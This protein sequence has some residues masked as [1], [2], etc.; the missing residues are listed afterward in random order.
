ME[1]KQG[2]KLFGWM[3]RKDDYESGGHIGVY[4]RKNTNLKLFLG[5]KKQM[6]KRQKMV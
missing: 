1:K 3:A 2:D 6:K 5:K 4:L